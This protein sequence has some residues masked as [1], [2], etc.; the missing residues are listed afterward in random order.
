MLCALMVLGGTA[1]LAAQQRPRP[2]QIADSAHRLID[3]ARKAGSTA[4]LADATAFLERGLV[5]FERDALLLHYKGYSLYVAATLTAGKDG[6]N[7]R[8]LLEGA[9]AA[10]ESSARTLKLPETH[11][12][13]SAVI[14]Q[15][16]GAN[17]LRGITLGPRSKSAMERAR[18]LGP[19]NPRV[20]ML[21]GIG[22]IFTPGMFGGGMDKAEQRLRRAVELFARQT[23]PAPPTPRW[24]RAESHAWL[25]QV[26]Q[27]TGRPDSARV[28]YRR[29]L[30]LEPDNGWIRN[31]LLP[32]LDRDSKTGG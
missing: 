16:I 3:A 7:P 32:A 11:A 18:A 8:A 1:P 25:G 24:G 20:W 21:D 22:A 12:L 6:Q 27:R 15:Q 14:G 29:A 30:E 17:P 19:E 26:F 13:L 9:Q 31:V 2:A 28:H 4:G 5:A 23:D 10:L